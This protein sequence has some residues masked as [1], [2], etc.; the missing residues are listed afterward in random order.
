MFFLIFSDTNICFAK[1]E[2]IW[3]S[4]I[5]KK[6]LSI[7]KRVELIN[8]KKFAKAVLDENSETFVVYMLMLKAAKASICLSPAA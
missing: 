6:G 4:Y 7:T 5:T 1:K 8:K 2:L 3:K